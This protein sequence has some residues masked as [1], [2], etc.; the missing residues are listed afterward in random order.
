MGVSL[1]QQTQEQLISPQLPVTTGIATGDRQDAE[2]WRGSRAAAA[3]SVKLE[4]KA[5]PAAE[6]AGET[7]CE[8]STPTEAKLLQGEREGMPESAN[9]GAGQGGVLPSRAASEPELQDICSEPRVAG[10]AGIE[11]GKQIVAASGKVADL[12][13]APETS[14]N[15]RGSDVQPEPAAKDGSIVPKGVQA[16]RDAQ[17]PAEERISAAKGTKQEAAFTKAGSLTGILAAPKQQPIQIADGGGQEMTYRE[18]S[19][20]KSLIPKLEVSASYAHP[21]EEAVASASPRSSW[22]SV[23]PAPADPHKP[24]T[25]G[26][27]G[28]STGPASRRS[29]SSPNLQSLIQ[30]VS[31]LPAPPSTFDTTNAQPGLKVTAATSVFA[32]HKTHDA[33]AYLRLSHPQ[34][35]SRIPRPTANLTNQLPGTFREPSV[36][37]TADLAVPPSAVPQQSGILEPSVLATA[38]KGGPPTMLP[39][40]SSKLKSRAATTASRIS[41]PSRPAKQPAAATEPALLPQPAEAWPMLAGKLSAMAEALVL[42][43]RLSEELAQS[44]AAAPP[45]ANAGAKATAVVVAAAATPPAEAKW[46]LPGQSPGSGKDIVEVTGSTPM[47][48]W[49]L[50]G[51]AV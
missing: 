43:A 13:A 20:A 6:S 11:Q 35:P 41:S 38:E 40:G 24:S 30:Q 47:Q 18:A 19:L 15:A 29:R 16:G 3:Q 7:A 37:A 10:S 34:Q 36:A 9:G 39:K 17:T 45:A 27:S 1:W 21:R 28:S 46:K 22:A 5:Q 2:S 31:R 49:L 26:V 42:S 33:T 25:G 14:G 51:L 50:L 32:G 44:N 12:S 8:G 23:A 4:L 48:G